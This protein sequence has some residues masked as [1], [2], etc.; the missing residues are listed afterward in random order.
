MGQ[1]LRTLQGI[2]MQLSSQGYG[3]TGH[4]RARGHVQ[5]AIHELNTALAIR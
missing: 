1:A 2:H 3:T 5:R 4:A